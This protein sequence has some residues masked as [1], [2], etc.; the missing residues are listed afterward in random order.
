MASPSGMFWM[1][2]SL[3]FEGSALSESAARRPLSSEIHR[4]RPGD[5]HA[6]EGVVRLDLLFHLLLDPREVLR[7]DP[8]RQIDVVIE[9]VVDR[10][11]GGKLRF[12]PN[13]Q[14]GRGQHMRA[15]VTESFDVSHGDWES[16]TEN[17]PAQPS[18]SKGNA[19]FGNQQRN[20]IADGI[21]H[22]A[23]LA[24]QALSNRPG[25]TGTCTDELRLV[26]ESKTLVRDRTANEFQQ[27]GI[28]YS[29]T[30]RL[31]RE[32]ARKMNRTGQPAHNIDAR[33][34]VIRR[35]FLAV[36]LSALMSGDLN[37]R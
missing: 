21:K 1:I 32:L 26:S 19:F 30:F 5:F 36:V 15:G 8:V 22:I 33:L 10:R 14:D 17:Q 31:R 25:R 12:R 18:K 20:P 11:T 27:R 28:H 24:N 23:I 13:A 16:T 4:L 3:N 34:M 35:S 2:S 37:R 7:R 29:I 9:A 6:L